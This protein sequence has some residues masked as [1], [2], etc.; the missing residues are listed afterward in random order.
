MRFV[1]TILL[2]V[3]LSCSQHENDSKVDEALI[4]VDHSGALIDFGDGRYYAFYWITMR[5]DNTVTIWNADVY[6]GFLR[7]QDTVGAKRVWFGGMGAGIEWTEK[8]LNIFDDPNGLEFQVFD[9]DY[10]EK[11]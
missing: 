3:A 11:R 9:I 2:F 7:G 1:I 4:T 8:Y 6:C 5:N 10:T